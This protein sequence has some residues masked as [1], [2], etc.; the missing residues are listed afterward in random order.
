MQKYNSMS[1]HFAYSSFISSFNP[2]PCAFSN[3]I[4]NQNF[5]QTNA[6]A[7]CFIFKQFDPLAISTL[8]FH[9]WHILYLTLP[10]QPNIWMVPITQPT[11][12]RFY[13]TELKEYT[14]T[15]CTHSSILCT[16]YQ[17]DLPEVNARIPAFQNSLPL[18]QFPISPIAQL[19]RI[20]VG[21]IVF[22]C[23]FLLQR[24]QAS[25]ISWGRCPKLHS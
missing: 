6:P 22:M 12:S 24:T 7:F 19:P 13:M 3:F 20:N 16:T 11:T 21:F 8:S 23:A 18:V 15:Q 17:W 10:I 14:I 1:T 25:S 4:Q 5:N 9:R 2:K